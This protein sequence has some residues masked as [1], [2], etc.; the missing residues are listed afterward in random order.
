MVNPLPYLFIYHIIK[1]GVNASDGPE[2]A[3]RRCHGAGI[4]RR[5]VAEFPFAHGHTVPDMRDMDDGHARLHRLEK[6]G[7]RFAHGDGGAGAAFEIP[8]AAHQGDVLRCA[9]GNGVPVA[10]VGTGALAIAAPV[11]CRRFGNIIVRT[12]ERG[13]GAMRRAG[14]ATGSGATARPPRGGIQQDVG[15]VF[16]R[17]RDHLSNTNAPAAQPRQA[18]WAEV[19]MA[20]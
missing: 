19:G 1:R 14:A 2:L 10:L 8:D 15:R 11:G 5:S 17:E 4:D 16:R 13:R 3:R 9:E 6:A 7:Q 12:R 18:D 20:V